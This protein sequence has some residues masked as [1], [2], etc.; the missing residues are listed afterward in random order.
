MSLSASPVASSAKP[1]ALITG[2]GSGIGRATAVHFAQNHF[3][4]ILVGRRRELLQETARLCLNA[5]ADALAQVVP[6]DLAQTDDIQKMF[7]ELHA[8]HPSLQVAINNAG[9]EGKIGPIAEL[10]VSDFDEVFAINVRGLWLCNQ[11]EIAWMK[12]Q[13]AQPE[14]ARKNPWMGVRSI[15][16]LSSVAGLRGIPT[17][18]IYCASKFAVIG[19]T[20]ALA[21]EVASQGLR[22]NAI[23]PGGVATPMLQRIYHN[24]LASAAQGHPTGTLA[25]PAEIAAAA[26][27]LCSPEARFVTGSQLVIDGGLT[28]GL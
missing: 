24:N 1:L 19:L 27:W 16:N 23:C 25:T 6:C 10:K 18:S 3:R 20:Q 22:I 7:T 8:Q 11:L 26:L 13:T 5:S 14:P 15:V 28:A 17:S 4:V 12:A 2:A 9:I 21:L